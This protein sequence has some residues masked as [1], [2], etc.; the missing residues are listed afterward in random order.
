M[1]S[2]AERMFAI[3]HRRHRKP[4]RKRAFF[5]DAIAPLRRELHALLLRGAAL[6]SSRASGMCRTLLRHERSLWV[7]LDSKAVEP[8]N[9]AVERA[10][11]P[12]VLWRKRSFGT[13]SSDGSRFVERVLTAVASLRAR[14]ANVF[15]FLVSTCVA[16]LVGN[17]L[18]S[19]FEA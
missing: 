9:N 6:S 5:V 15:Q 18:P 11:R 1:L 13:D 2:I 14:G 4:R 17:R 10:I 12:A 3:W 7:F 8:T 19:L 16:A